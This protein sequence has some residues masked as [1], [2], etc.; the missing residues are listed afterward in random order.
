LLHLAPAEAAKQPPDLLMIEL[1]E[2]LK[3]GPLT[4]HLKA[5][6][7]APNDPTVDATKPS[8]DSNQV[9]DLSVLTVYQHRA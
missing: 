5:Q 3:H 4:V 6:V 9:V 8:P 7:A 1:P 2:R